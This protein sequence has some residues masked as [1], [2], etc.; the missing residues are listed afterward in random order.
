M[1]M[2]SVQGEE[3]A[4]YDRFSAAYAQYLKGQQPVL[5][6]MAADHKAEALALLTKPELTQLNKDAADALQQGVSASI[7][8]TAGTP[9]SA[10][11][12]QAPGRQA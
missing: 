11:Q 9:A 1:R 3:K 12:R 7:S 5:D 8:V 2:Q 4:V 6:A 10:A